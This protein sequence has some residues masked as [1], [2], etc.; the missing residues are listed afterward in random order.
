M[1]K[2]QQKKHEE[3]LSRK[4]IATGIELETSREHVKI[5]TRKINE[6]D[7]ELMRVYQQR[8]DLKLT[9]NV[10]A[11]LLV[12]AQR[13][14]RD[15]KPESPALEMTMCGESLTDIL[16]KFSDLMGKR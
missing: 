15:R 10:L 12:E 2:S 5:L 13:V 16:K 1:K 3:E 8:D 14:P 9:A 7:S 11:G 6:K 4:L